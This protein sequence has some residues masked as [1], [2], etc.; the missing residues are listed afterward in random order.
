MIP[1]STF[2]SL[3]TFLFDVLPVLG[4]FEHSEVV[5]FA[6]LKERSHDDILLSRGCGTSETYRQVL[7]LSPSSQNN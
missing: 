4:L 5:V 6:I 7:T 1:S 2:T 3:S